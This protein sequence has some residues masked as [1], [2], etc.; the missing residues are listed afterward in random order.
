MKEGQKC[1][2]QGMSAFSICI[3]DQLRAGFRGLSKASCL[4]SRC[5]NLLEFYRHPHNCEDTTLQVSCSK[6]YVLC[7]QH[8]VEVRLEGIIVQSL[9]SKQ[10]VPTLILCFLS[11]PFCVL[12]IDPSR[13]IAG[14]LSPSSYKFEC[15]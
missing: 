14:K 8:T 15:G 6:V 9:S 11:A 3:L 10:V 5:A 13:C 1:Y 12:P 2:N 4:V 7:Q